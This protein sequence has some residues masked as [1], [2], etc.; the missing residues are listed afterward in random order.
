[1][2]VCVTFGDIM[3]F[4]CKC[5][6]AR[7]YVFKPPDMSACLYSLLTACHSVYL[8]VSLPVSLSFRSPYVKV[9]YIN[10]TFSLKLLRLSWA[11]PIGLF[12][13]CVHHVRHIK[14]ERMHSDFR[15][16]R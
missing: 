12:F 3:A 5:S 2:C 14:C 16:F 4:M 1:M 9:C 13:L 10:I 15:T 8:S 11:A 6:N 7:F